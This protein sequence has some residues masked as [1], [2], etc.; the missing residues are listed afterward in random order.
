MIKKLCMPALIYFIY[1]FS[2]VILDSGIGRYNLAIMKLVVTVL[3]TLMLNILCER[4]LTFVSWVIIFIP[5]ILMSMIVSILLVFFGLDPLTGSKR[6]NN[7][8]K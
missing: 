4:G 3:F 6:K 7:I 2:Q 5:F 8:K 1:S